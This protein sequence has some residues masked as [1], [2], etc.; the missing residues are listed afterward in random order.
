M[1]ELFQRRRGFRRS[2][3]KVSMR[4]SRLAAASRRCRFFPLARLFL[5]QNL[6]EGRKTRF[7]RNL[8]W[9]QQEPNQS[10]SE[11]VLFF[12]SLFVFRRLF[13]LICEDF[14]RCRLGS[15]HSRA[16]LRF[17]RSAKRLSFRQ[18]SH[19]DSWTAKRSPPS[20]PLKFRLPLL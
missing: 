14:L 10:Q 15:Q 2:S 11:S 12:E 17:L 7:R 16:A 3:W 4:N 6:A 19:A 18:L 1:A 13:A 20:L 5:P 8:P 9:H